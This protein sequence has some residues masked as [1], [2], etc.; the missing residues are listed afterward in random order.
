[1]KNAEQLIIDMKD[2]LRVNSAMKL[3][4]RGCPAVSYGQYGNFFARDPQCWNI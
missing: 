1:M 4:C 2:V 3:W